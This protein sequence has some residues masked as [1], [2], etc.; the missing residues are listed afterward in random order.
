MKLVQRVKSWFGL[1]GSNRGMPWGFGELGTPFQFYAEQGFQRNLD[2]PRNPA[3]AAVQAAI[4]KYTDALVT[5]PLG[6]FDDDGTERIKSSAF[7]R[8]TRRPNAWQTLAEWMSEGERAL[9]ETGNA[10]GVINRND[11]TEISTITWASYWS[12]HI[13]PVSG[14]VFYAVQMPQQ[15]GEFD[16]SVLIPARDILHLRINADGR[17]G[18][19]RGRS[20]LEWCAAALATNATLS[21]FLV[22]YLNNRASPS[23]A[24]STEAQLTA[25]QMRQLRTSWNEQSQALKSGGTPIL[26]NGLKPVML[27]T[28]PGDTLL[29]ETFNLS[30]EDVARAFGLPKALL[31]IDETA[32]N[33]SALIREWVSLGLGAHIEMWEQALEK[34]FEM[35]TGECVEF[36]THAL[37]R[38]APHEEAQRLKELVT[39]G[40][41]AADEARA[42]LSLSAIEGGYGKMPT[43]QQQQIPLDLLAELHAADIAAKNKPAPEPVAVEPESEPKPEDDK[44]FDDEVARA[45]VIELFK[46][47]AA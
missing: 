7:T 42:V 23:Y 31:G 24:L 22:S 2:L 17:R 25:E 40:I 3:I 45:L 29:V 46:R 41:M 12:A 19:L 16:S 26:Q 1:E 35:P 10:V 18:P 32:S 33:A 6:H 43:M 4:S 21:A 36:D 44:A 11:R 38:M 9:M 14:A 47:K 13:D 8:W 30:V 27:G 34:A 37:L 5:M 20:P 28:A 39:G 15:Y